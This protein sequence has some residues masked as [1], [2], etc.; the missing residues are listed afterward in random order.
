MEDRHTY[1]RRNILSGFLFGV[2]LVAF[3][4][5]AVFHQLLHWH[6]FYD[7]S[8]STWGLVSDGFFHALSWFATVGGLFLFA[9]LRRRRGLIPLRWGGAVL[10]GCG[11][12]Q[13]YDGLI[14]H[15]LFR[16]HQIRYG[17]DIFYYDLI[18]NGIAVL[19]IA[20]GIWCIRRSRRKEYVR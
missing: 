16:I 20:A 5:E 10:L 8:S 2:G 3:I 18:W 9:D 6:H 13:L 1:K 12:F 4:D 19:L 7:L 17:V 14:Q 15:K 11:V